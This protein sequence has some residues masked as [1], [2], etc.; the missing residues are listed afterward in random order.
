MK[1]EKYIS[2]LILI[3]YCF[4]L[5]TGCNQ[6]TETSDY[7]E[8][9]ANNRNNYYENLNSKT[10]GFGGIVEDKL[11]L[12]KDLYD[13]SHA[14]IIGA[15]DYKQGWDDLETVPGEIKKIEAVLK[16][17]NF[18]TKTVLNPTSIM[19]FN[20]YNDFVCEY[21]L[22]KNNR[23][24]LFF[25]GHGWTRNDGKN[26]YIVPVDAP[27]PRLDDTGFVKKAVGMQQILTWAKKIESKHAL[28][29]FDSCFSGTIFKTKSMPAKPPDITYKTSRPV[30]QFIA[31]G[32]S[33]KEIRAQSILIPILERALN[34]EGDLDND[35]F[36]TG[37]ELGLH[38]Q[39]KVQE[40]DKDQVPQCN[41]IKDTDLN[42][43]DFVFYLASSSGAT[44]EKNT[45]KNAVSIVSFDADVPNSEIFLNDNFKG[46]TP[47]IIK[48][49]KPGPYNLVI[50][51]DGYEPYKN[52]LKIFHGKDIDIKAWLKK[53]VTTG[54]IKITGSPPG[55]NVYVD[56]YLVDNIPCIIEQLKKGTHQI[57]IEK[58]GYEL[59]NNIVNVE[60][61]KQGYLDVRLKKIEILN[62]QDNTQYQINVDKIINKFGME[63]VYIKP[64]SFMMGSPEDEQGRFNNEK[65]HKVTLTKGF[66]AQTTEVTQGQWKA[67]MGNNPSYFQNCGDDCPVEKVSWNDVQE[68]INKLN[69]NEKTNKYRLPTEA[70]WEYAARAGSKTALYSGNIEILGDHNAPA[71][72]PIAWYGGNS[73]VKYKGGYD[74][75]GWNS[76]QYQCSNCG[77][78][79]VG[80]K[81]PNEWGLYDMIGNVDEWCQDWYVDYPSG[82]VV[83][84]SGPSSGS[85]RVFR[86]GAWYSYARNCRSAYRSYYSPG[87]SL[88]N[89]GFRL[90]RTP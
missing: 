18:K 47:L 43:G 14:L 68:F 76:K 20:A 29:I 37:T 52:K 60:A 83:N 19:L 40:I 86:G 84:P 63:F 31:A 89:V 10:K 9:R 23:L 57:R 32:S 26:G 79:P 64:G 49:L 61:G 58:N 21:G 80:K 12:Y 22:K 55:A 36:I 24:L 66:Y 82:N 73:C 7:I 81:Q 39:K 59:W 51:K 6:F 85:H 44:T 50:K 11:A 65:Q 17:H 67:I 5:Q 25:S 38:L 42:E 69:K 54:N 27:D 88:Y 30:R 35:G 33:D 28:F 77:T 3:A 74:C 1:I 16:K 62:D 2:L 41:K 48:N 56:D 34:G 71:L 45:K 78:H 15:S 13:E 72:D 4:L 90:F 46:N 8:N 87:D 75:S 53:I 70:E